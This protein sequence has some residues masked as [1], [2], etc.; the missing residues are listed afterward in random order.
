MSRSLAL[1]IAALC[2]CVAFA[3]DSVLLTNNG[4]HNLQF[5]QYKDAPKLDTGGSY[6]VNPALASPKE[7]TSFSFAEGP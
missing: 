5:S 6:M 7:P 3:Q 2:A 4:V 1:L